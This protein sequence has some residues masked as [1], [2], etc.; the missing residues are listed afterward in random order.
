VPFS[1]GHP[2]KSF[3]L[4]ARLAKDAIAIKKIEKVFKIILKI[5]E[6]IF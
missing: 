6:L 3:L 2:Q 4:M 1:D 5:K